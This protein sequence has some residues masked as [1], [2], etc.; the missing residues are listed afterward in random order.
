MF[1]NNSAV[2]KQ[3]AIP[4]DVKMIYRLSC[5]KIATYVQIFVYIGNLYAQIHFLKEIH[6]KRQ[7][8]HYLHV[9]LPISK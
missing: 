8:W 2:I 3:Q 1:F 7:N 4:L 9:R 6:S 5:K